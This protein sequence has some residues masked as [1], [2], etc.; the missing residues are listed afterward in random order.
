VFNQQG[1]EVIPGFQAALTNPNAGGTLYFTLDGS[2][3]RNPD[4]TPHGTLYTEPITVETLT[5]I[6]ARVLGNEVWSPLSEATFTVPST[7]DLIIS[8]IMYH[9]PDSGD[10]SGTRLE[11]IELR[12]VGDRVAR[13]DGFQFTD[14]IMYTFPLGT[15]L[16]AGEYLVLASDAVEFANHYGGPEAFGQFE[17]NLENAGERIALSDP[18]GRE[19]LAFTY[20]DQ[21]PWP[22]SPDGDGYSLVLVDEGR[23]T[24]ASNPANWRASLQVGGS[25]GRADS[26]SILI[27]IAADGTGVVLI[28]DNFWVIQTSDDLENWT[29]LPTAVSPLTVPISATTNR[30]WRLRMP[31]ASPAEIFHP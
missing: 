27:S 4:N 15:T 12:N 10:I 7:P 8:E 29:D 18:T 25:P 9:P 16:A 20:D 26:A 21:L 2:D 6:K 3:P 1:G 28:W 31:Q 17:G 23:I 13:L 30:F 14:G 19:T 11:F 22:T 5:M 24:D